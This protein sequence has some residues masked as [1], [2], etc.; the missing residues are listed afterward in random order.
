MCGAHSGPDH[1]DPSAA[2]LCDSYHRFDRSDLPA[3]ERG[4]DDRQKEIVWQVALGIGPSQLA[5]RLGCD[6]NSVRGEI[7]SLTE[8]LRVLQGTR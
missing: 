8:R 6:I 3:L 4:L 7:R 2:E 5:E 1:D